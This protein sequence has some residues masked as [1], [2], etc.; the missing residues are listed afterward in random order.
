MKRCAD[1]K[2]LFRVAAGPRRGFGHLVRARA[3]A[4]ALGVRPLVS[5]RGGIRVVE[6]ALALGCDVIKGDSPACLAAM[7]PDVVVVDDPIA[8]DAKRWIAA[9][10]R[11]GSIVVTV[12]DL[13]LGQADGDL[14]VDGSVITANRKSGGIQLMGPRY[15][16]LDPALSRDKAADRNCMRVLI[17]LGGGPRTELATS[18]AI[19]LSKIVP[20]A[21]IRIV[22]GFYTG[23]VD[24]RH[25]RIHW[26]ETTDGL[27][28]ELRRTDIAVVGGGVSLYEACAMGVPAVA[29]PVVPSQ[30]PTVA[31][32]V[33]RGAAIG[34][35]KVGTAPAEIARDAA[36]LLSDGALRRHV[37]RTAQA[38]VDGRGALRVAQAIGQLAGVAGR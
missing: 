29:V 33:S 19:A 16:V 11:S 32:M 1:L 9:A 6:A 8:S 17:S 35:A 12:H 10:R 15:A 27:G 5:V 20:D 25:P 38:L 14:I 26:I 30:R 28:A 22:G 13:G 31:A 36:K 18:I 37:R 21:D 2:V 7:Q 23:I 3:L 4:R 34:R 24:M